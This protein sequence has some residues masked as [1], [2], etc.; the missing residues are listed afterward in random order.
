MKSF[1]M[2][3]EGSFV[4]AA[5]SLVTLA[6]AAMTI[7]AWGWNS[8]NVA[9]WV[10]AVGSIAAIIGSY[11]IGERQA[12]AALAAT[13]KAHQLAE[14]TRQAVEALEELERRQGMYAV[15]RAAYTHTV[16]IKEA[17]SDELNIKMY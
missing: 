1:R 4:I 14:E 2:I 13:Q 3:A 7:H 16:Q 12:K 6:V 9:S 17:L 15:I 10:Q 11:F 8:G 5:T